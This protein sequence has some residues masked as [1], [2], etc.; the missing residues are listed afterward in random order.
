MIMDKV[1]NQFFNSKIKLYNLKIFFIWANENWTDNENFLPNENGKEKSIK[2]IYNHLEF[3]KNSDNLMKYFK[4]KNYLKIHNKPVLFIYHTELITD[5]NSFFYI[6]NEECINSGFDGVHLVLNSFEKTNDNFKNFYINFNYKKYDCR[7]FDE[8][9]KQIK[10]DYRRYMNDPHHYK[11]NKI[12]TVAYDFDNRP[13]LYKPY[14]LNNSTICINNSHTNK[15]VLTK[16]IIEL[17]KDVEENELDKILLIN[18]LNEWG[19]NMTFEPS[20][21][22]NYYNINLLHDLLNS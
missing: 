3:K 9:Q 10:L 12:Q 11:E 1:I 6:L 20:N 2:N 16:K 15:I 4:N 13:R 14:N 17:Y 22:Y 21:K 18:A 8:N 7:Y 19:E 5:I